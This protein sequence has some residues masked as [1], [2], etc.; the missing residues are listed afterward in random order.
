MEEPEPVQN[1]E[2]H[3]DL[4]SNEDEEQLV[5][6]QEAG[7]FKV[8]PLDLKHD[9]NEPEEKMNQLVNADSPEGEKQHQQDNN[10]EESGSNTDE[11]H[12]HTKRQEKIKDHNDSSKVKRHKTNKPCEACGKCFTK[13]YLSKHVRTHTGEKPFSCPICAKEFSQKSNLS[14][15]IRTHT[16]EKPYA[17][18]MCDKSFNDGSS[19]TCHMRTHTGEKPFSCPT[20]AKGFSQIAHLNMHKKTH[21]GKNNSHVIGT[22]K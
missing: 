18:E 17:C 12:K 22:R 14:K 16:G 9:T 1:K 2:E 3:G 11:E 7:T 8:T 13:Y 21:M 10:Q 6:K 4:W 20:C 19:L 5:V 15:H